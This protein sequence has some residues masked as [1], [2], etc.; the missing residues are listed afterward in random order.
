VLPAQDQPRAAISIGP[1]FSRNVRRDVN[2]FGWQSEL[3]GY[4]GK[5]FGIAVGDGSRYGKFRHRFD[6]TT[7]SFFAGPQVRLPTRTGVTPFV[8]VFGGIAHSTITIDRISRGSLLG[9]SISGNHG[10]IGAGGGV[11]VRVSPHVSIRAIRADYWI[12]RT[13]GS[14]GGLDIGAG[15]VLTF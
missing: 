11:D 5:H 3:A 4:F 12:I 6:A 10:G 13:T 14:H 1:A 9:G 7:H 8:Q 2:G 15:I